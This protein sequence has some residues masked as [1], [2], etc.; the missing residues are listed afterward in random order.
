MVALAS[1]AYIILLAV[2]YLLRS[3]SPDW[4]LSS[5]ESDPAYLRTRVFFVT[6]FKLLV[7]TALAAIF[8][9]AFYDV[10]VLR[11]RLP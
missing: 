6:T 4:M 3:P 2:L 10:C 9:G 11:P 5:E 1:V 7:V 8:L